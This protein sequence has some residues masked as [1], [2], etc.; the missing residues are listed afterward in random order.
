MRVAM[1]DQPGKPLAITTVADPTPEEDQVVVK[2]GRCGICSSDLHMTEGHGFTLPPGAVPGH[3]FSGEVVALGKG[4]THVAVGDLVSV[5]PALS[6]GRCRSC[7]GGMPFACELGSRTLGVGPT[8]GG[9]AEYAVAGG[10]WCVGLPSGL[11]MDD[12]ALIEPLAVGLHGVRL[13]NLQA[14]DDVLIIGAGPVGLAA[15]YWARRLGAGRVAVTASSNRREELART[16]GADL[17]ILPGEGQSLVDATIAAFG[18]KADVV[19]E[20]S[21][22]PGML[23]RSIA[24]VRRNGTVVVLGICSEPETITAL[25][26]VM[27]EVVLRFAFAADRREFEVCLDALAKGG[28]EPRAM[29]TGAVT[30]EETPAMFEALRTSKTHSKVMINPWG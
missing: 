21:G 16:M 2:V 1:F 24:S 22:V 10:R 11:S 15:A 7:L 23:D 6:C 25:P 9:Y 30:L 3:E 12:G 17:F 18:G 5:L 8:W 26:A 4:V 13:A 20:C 14:G 19:L 27:N 29:I 28:V